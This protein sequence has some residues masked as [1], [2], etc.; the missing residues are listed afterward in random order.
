LHAKGKIMSSDAPPNDVNC[1]DLPADGKV[2]SGEML[3][4]IADGSGL[5][6]GPAFR[7][8]ENVSFHGKE[9]IRVE[10]NPQAATKSFLLNPVHLDCCCQ[11][12]IMLFPGLRAAE[13]GVAYIPV[14]FDSVTLHQSGR[15]PQR[16]II[17][18]ISQNERSIYANFYIFAGDGSVTATLR[19]VRCQA[20]PVRRSNA[21]ETVAFLE[22]S[23]PADGSVL[24]RSGL[25]TT[26]DD[27]VDKVNLLSPPET[28]TSPRSE[29]MQLLDGWAMMVVYEIM[30]ALAEQN[31]IDLDRLIQSGRVSAPLRSWITMLLSKLTVAKLAQ[32][33]NASWTLSQNPSLPS[34]ASI[35]KELAAKHPERAGELL[36]AAEITGLAGSLRSKPA[37][38]LDAEFCLSKISVDFY[39]AAAPSVAASSKMLLQVL[40]QTMEPWPRDRSIRV[41][42][43]GIGP[44]IQELLKW[45]NASLALTVFEPDRR[46]CEKA[47]T[48]LANIGNVR[49]IDTLDSSVY[50]LIVATEALHL[51]P[52]TT[53]VADLRNVLAPSG[54]L[55][56]IEPQ[57]SLF[58]E[59]VYGMRM[60]AQAM[61]SD[62]VPTQLPTAKAWSE[63]ISAAGLKENYAED[64]RYGDDNGVVLIVKR[65]K[66]DGHRQLEG[67]QK[68]NIHIVRGLGPAPAKLADALRQHLTFKESRADVQVSD[69]FD[70]RSWKE[71]P[72]IVIHIISVDSDADNL[73]A[74]SQA[75]LEMK[76]CA[77]RLGSAPGML[78]HIFHGARALPETSLYPVQSGAWAF[79]RTLANEFQH[80]DV[81]RI[82]IAGDLLASKVAKQI[83]TIIHSQTSE[84]D[85]QIDATTIHVC[86][87]RRFERPTA[88]DMRTAPAAK[89]ERGLNSSQRLVWQPAM[90]KRPKADEIEIEVA[91]TGL[92]FRDLMY[93][94][95]LL[96]DD[97]LED[98]FSGPTLGLECAGTVVGMGTSVEN[99]KIGDRV[100]T[101]APTAFSTHVIVSRAHVAKIP[102]RISFEAAATIPAA[103]ST[104]Y[105][106][107]IELAKLKRGEWVLI[108]A[109]SGAVGMAAIQI[110][111]RQGARVIATA[112]AEAKRSFLRAL[113]VH[114]VLDS[115]TTQFVED[116]RNITGSGVDVVLNSLSGDAME[117]SLACLTTFGRFI[118]LGKRDFVTNTHIGLRPF[119]KNLSY[120]GVDMDQ[121]SA[122]RPEV[123]RKV[124]TKIM[125][126]FENGAFKPLP[127][128]VFGS[129]AV[130]DAFQLMQKAGHIGKIIVRP[131][132]PRSIH[133]PG[134]IFSVDPE[135]THFITGGLGGLGLATAKW[136]AD[137][138]ARHLVLISRRGVTTDEAKNLISDL[139]RRGVSVLAESCDVADAKQLEILFNKMQKTMP[140]LCGIIHSA[141]VLDDSI[142]ANLTADRIDHV[143]APKVRGA[144]NLDRIT[145]NL[146]LD[147]FVMFSSV[148]TLIGNRG[149][150]SYVAAN[151]YL[152]GLAHRRRKDGLP[153][154]AI[155]W[156][157]ITDVGVVA[158]TERM[159]V[160]VRKI[161]G[162]RGM[163]AKEALDLMGLA[164]TESADDVSLAVI[165]IAP[166]EAAFSVDLLP[167]LKSPTYKNLITS[168]DQSIQGLDSK[169]DLRSL[170]A[171]QDFVSV[172]ETVIQVIMGQLARVLLLNKEDVSLVRPLSEMGLD[173]LMALE[174]IMNLEEILGIQLSPARV[175]GNMPSMPVTKFADEIIA[176]V[177]SQPDGEDNSDAVRIVEQ[178]IVNVEPE[179]IAIVST[180]LQAEKQHAGIV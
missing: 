67:T 42:Q 107:L 82:D 170:L 109:G 21:L 12:L 31:I 24:E 2:I 58:R 65:H 87:V 64:V 146:S 154:L 103:F 1:P 168:Q 3:Y 29:S 70:S 127:Y 77:E 81:R 18:I 54:L 144:D 20:V 138:G 6:Y 60:Q 38:N 179:Q 41:L 83:A 39:D 172:R 26:L 123:S 13:R 119:R 153:A 50:D 147:Y 105:Y 111:Q 51:L 93:V 116:V 129:A 94:L 117:R 30:S 177:G 108:H 7:Q 161:G 75:C 163:R 139:S 79:S 122:S 164:L 52:L 9:L 53:I 143:L 106:S 148:V 96:P 124:F 57:P 98:G 140:R 74:L 165:T 68:Q 95:R 28:K 152:E 49:V 37:A 173:S 47:K 45:P 141:M 34:S 175:A 46:K 104:A 11:G 88:V 176:S 5:H 86:R 43:I 171:T 157:P 128:S 145:R 125:R 10:L 110:A 150:G 118:E 73:K 113:G 97:I 16:S 180:M 17:E 89:L 15:I 158:R 133:V 4:R 136:L 66:S 90:R 61:Q 36:I 142:V 137:H 84:T 114:H 92:N 101:M 35:I 85:L 91:V 167:I 80:L 69:V 25:Q 99:L 44:L 126:G 56:A 32:Q 120:F 130:S 178:H 166:H 62:Q 22:S 72:N 102:D 156:G 27:I 112:G 132:D 59:L 33:R 131:P 155:G 55:L 76:A 19:G 14:R 149:Q 63:I 162:V 71:V 134:K 151:A 174:L 100:V 40:Q 78:L 169:I 121:V 8:I 159:R 23:E 115:R 160:D 48:S 135:G